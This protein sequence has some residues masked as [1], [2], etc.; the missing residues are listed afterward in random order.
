MKNEGCSLKGKEI[1][2]SSDIKEGQYPCAQRQDIFKIYDDG[3]NFIDDIKV[4]MEV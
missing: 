1:E 4:K 3:N 2:T